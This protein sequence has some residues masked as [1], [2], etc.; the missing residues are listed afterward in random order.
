MR[1]VLA[2]TDAPLGQLGDPCQEPGRERRSPDAGR[3]GVGGRSLDRIAGDVLGECHFP[4]Y[5]HAHEHAAPQPETE[6]HAD[7]RRRPR[8][9]RDGVR[10]RDP[11]G[12][13]EEPGQLG[14]PDRDDRHAPRLEVLE[15]GGHIE[16]GLRPGADDRH[17]GP[18][19]LLEVRRDVERCAA[20]LRRPP[21][22]PRCTPPIPPVA[23]TRIPA[24]CAAIIV[25][26]TVVAAQPPSLSATASVGR[27]A[28]RTEPAGRGRQRLERLR[29]QPH[30]Q[31]PVADRDRRRHGAV[32]LADRRLR[33]ERDLEIL[34]VRQP[35]ADERRLERD[36]G[37]AVGEGRWRPRRPRRSVRA[38]QARWACRKP[39]VAATLP[40][41]R[42]ADR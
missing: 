35:V 25:A 41:C 18:A 2:R 11:R 42:R 17:R 10:R 27:A 33:R 28:L 23:N 32:G 34:R 13:G 38:R 12:T 31:P 20:R 29:I 7:D 26:E 24:A 3:L 39:S 9:V 8:H 4:G 5:R 21:S 36:H 15:R 30:E 37:P 1:A 40:T 19:Q 16:D 14:L 6:V 22:A